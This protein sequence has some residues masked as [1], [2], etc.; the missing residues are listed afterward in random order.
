MRPSVL[1]TRC[2]QPDDI[3]ASANRRGSR[4]PRHLPD[5]TYEPPN[6]PLTL[7]NVV[8]AFVPTA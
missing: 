6:W 1:W 2:E 3:F 5:A 8:W 7:V 4:W